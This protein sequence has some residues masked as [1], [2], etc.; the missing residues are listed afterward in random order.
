MVIKIRYDQLKKQKAQHI[1]NLTKTS[2]K[3]Q[4]IKY[5]QSINEELNHLED[6]WL[7]GVEYVR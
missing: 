6:L 3:K 1:I 2:N 5:I 7:S 4:I